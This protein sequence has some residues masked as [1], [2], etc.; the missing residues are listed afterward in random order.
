MWTRPPPVCSSSAAPNVPIQTHAQSL[1][2]AMAALEPAMT[3]RHHDAGHLQAYAKAFP[4]DDASSDAA[5]Q[6][7]VLRTAFCK[8]F[9]RNGLPGDS[10]LR[11]ALSA[12]LWPNVFHDKFVL[13]LRALALLEEYRLELARLRHGVPQ[14]P[15]GQ[16][17]R[18][19]VR[20]RG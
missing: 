10:V 9:L 8:P 19:L 5:V 7:A 13:H 20:G 4:D 11:L 3:N 1:S 17:A 15:S 2:S 18:L 6:C 14:P 12:S 16:Q